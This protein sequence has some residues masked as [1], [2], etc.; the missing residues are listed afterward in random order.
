MILNISYIYYI[1][2][3]TY[4]NIKIQ[5]GLQ[6]RLHSAP[7]VKRETRIFPIGGR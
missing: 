6:R 5:E 3:Y 2:L 4:T 7:R 1:I